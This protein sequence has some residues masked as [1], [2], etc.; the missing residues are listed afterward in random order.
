MAAPFE[1]VGDP[2]PEVATVLNFIDCMNR[3]DIDGIDTLIAD[4]HTMQMLNEPPEVGR[5]SVVE[6]WAEFRF[7]IN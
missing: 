2:T 5:V 3:G 1:T 6:A 4:Q 7:P